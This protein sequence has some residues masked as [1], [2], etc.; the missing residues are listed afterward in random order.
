MILKNWARITNKIL[1]SCLFFSLSFFCSC[2]GHLRLR[3]ENISIIDNQLYASTSDNTIRIYDINKN[4]WRSS[5]AID[6][7]FRS[8]KQDKKNILIDNI[9]SIRSLDQNGNI[10]P[11]TSH[12]S[13]IF[14]L[15]G[16]ANNKIY[17]IVSRKAKETGKSKYSGF[18]YN[19]EE[20]EIID[21][22]FKNSPELIVLDLV[23]E[24]DQIWFF[25]VDG[26]GKSLSEP[27]GNLFIIGKRE[28][29][30][31]NI[32]SKLDVDV[33]GDIGVVNGSEKIFVLIH[34]FTKGISCK[35]L[36]YSFSKS[37]L[38]FR[39]VAV[40]ENNR[41]SAVPNQYLHTSDQFFWVYDRQNFAL[42]RLSINNYKISPF[43]IKETLG[44]GNFRGKSYC[45]PIL[46][47][48]GYIWKGI[49]LHEDGDYYCGNSYKPY[50]VKIADNGIKYE[51]IY[52]KPFFSE[53]ISNMY[54]SFLCST[55][56]KL[57]PPH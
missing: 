34:P 19:V 44:K 17:C 6:G 49:L 1:I 8:I 26:A 13:H 51:L 11:V 5:I 48:K 30:K 31:I 35:T 16:A 42:S 20:K 15:V 50:L 2:S 40:F 18:T 39:R 22:H 36:L 12:W 23:Q 54:K 38:T 47:D 21:N 33:C 32:R 37:S 46:H 3:V 10:S 14:R 53:A 4:I 7:K 25:C 45:P 41:F 24:S 9:Y 57:I 52:V 29:K 43:K 56:G 28:E 27:H 55:T